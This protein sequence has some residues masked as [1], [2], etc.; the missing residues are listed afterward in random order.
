[1]ETLG[2]LEHQLLLALLHIGS[3]SHAVPLVDLLEQ[4]TERRVSPTG[5][6]TVLRRLEKRGY[7][8]S[9]LGPSTPERGGRPKRLFT[10][11]SQALP[12]LRKTRRELEA[13][14]VGLDA[15]RGDTR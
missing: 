12:V 13:L 5:A 4:L 15:L 7:V 10:I 14:W 1:M 6:Y 2:E 11:S 9:R 8:T 3:E